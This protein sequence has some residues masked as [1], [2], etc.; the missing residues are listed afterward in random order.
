MLVHDGARPATARAD[1]EAVVAGAMASGAAI[2]GRAVADTIKRVRQGE[3]V[4]TVD[5]RELFRAETPQVARR[6][7][8]QAGLELAGREDRQETDEASLL[9]RVPGCRIRAVEARFPNPKL[10]RAA[11]LPLLEALLRDQPDER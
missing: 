6:D 5:R 3:I 9:E 2:L 8:L 7:L 1:V 10:T 4:E 11:D